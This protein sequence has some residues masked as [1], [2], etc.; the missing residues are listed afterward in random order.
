M[1]DRATPDHGYYHI[2]SLEQ[3][4]CSNFSCCGLALADMHQLLDHFEE[5]HVVVI[6]QDGRPIY[7]RTA[8]GRSPSASS[9]PSRKHGAS[10][11]VS[12]YPQPNPPLQPMDT[13]S[14]LP[15]DSMASR[16][17]HPPLQ[18]DV[19]ADFDPFEMDTASTSSESMSPPSS[20]F[21]TPDPNVPIC[22]PPALLSIH[23]QPFG[24]RED[25]MAWETTGANGHVGK[26]TGKAPQVHAK[27]PVSIRPAPFEV[28][29]RKTKIVEGPL[30]PVSPSKRRDREKMYKCPAYLNPNGLKYHLEKGTCTVD[31]AVLTPAFTR[32]DPAPAPSSP[33]PIAH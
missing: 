30:T 1:T 21:S 22:L 13:T 12:S 19:L 26:G 32:T 14:D 28:N 3:N 2:H 23:H 5:S 20:V 4:F 24:G 16:A 25:D 33:F 8:S 7:P 27:R 11:V 29:G 6:G 18:D 31:P 15:L 17:S 9:S 10:V